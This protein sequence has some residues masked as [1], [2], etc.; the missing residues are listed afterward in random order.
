MNDH[1]TYELKT[2]F[3][4]DLV[5]SES[6]NC[7]EAAAYYRCKS[8]VRECMEELNQECYFEMADTEV[9]IV[10]Y[11]TSHTFPIQLAYYEFNK[12]FG[13]KPG[14]LD[15]FFLCDDCIHSL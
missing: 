15:G 5:R 14:S 1:S 3:N 7:T 6:L 10:L 8:Y 12:R 11:E 13:F 2:F 4:N 9:K